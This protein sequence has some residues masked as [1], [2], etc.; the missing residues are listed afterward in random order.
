MVWA[1]S[2]GTD[3]SLLALFAGCVTRPIFASRINPGQIPSRQVFALFSGFLKPFDC[4]RNVLLYT[5]PIQVEPP[6][7]VLSHRVSLLR[8]FQIESGCICIVRLNT[9]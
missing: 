4:L 5:G 6:E 1:Y 8:R 2:Q 7:I 9:L 3:L